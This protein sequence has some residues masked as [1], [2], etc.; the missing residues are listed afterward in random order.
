MLR[1][2]GYCSSRYWPKICLMSVIWGLVKW[3]SY[4]FP[5]IPDAM[6]LT[7]E[8]IR[9]LLFRGAKERIASASWRGCILDYRRQ[10]HVFGFLLDGSRMDRE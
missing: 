9:E 5:K 1:E 7:N 3:R 6:A 4:A 10:V 8:L 2:Q